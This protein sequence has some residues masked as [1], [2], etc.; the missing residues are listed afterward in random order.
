LPLHLVL[1]SSHSGA[2]TSTTDDA[3]NGNNIYIYDGSGR[4]NSKK[5]TDY[6]GG[7]L[8]VTFSSLTDKGYGNAAASGS[9]YI[10]RSMDPDFEINDI[11]IVYRIKRV[12]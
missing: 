10:M 7:T 6:T 5:I 11:T 3:Y 8:T 1:A 9:K 2:D 12:K 4:F